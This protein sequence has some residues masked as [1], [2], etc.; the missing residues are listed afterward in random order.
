[1]FHLLADNLFVM[2]WTKL[3]L[4]PEPQV[5]SAAQLPSDCTSMLT[6]CICVK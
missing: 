3:E 1:M 4:D 2:W 6:K 5:D